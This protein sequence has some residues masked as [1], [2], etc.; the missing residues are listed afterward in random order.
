MH[1]ACAEQAPTRRQATRGAT[2]PSASAAATADTPTA[3]A[4]PRRSFPAR[5]TPCRPSVSGSPSHRAS[6][7]HAGR[8]RTCSYAQSPSIVRLPAG[9]QSEGAPGWDRPSGRCDG[10]R[11]TR[12]PGAHRTRPTRWPRADTWRGRPCATRAASQPE[13]SRPSPGGIARVGQT[14]SPERH[15]QPPAWSGCRQRCPRVPGRTC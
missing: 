10:T 6:A 8:P 13:R 5:T 1:I 15:W 14:S 7:P 3:P 2:W 4:V 12:R 9:G 11:C